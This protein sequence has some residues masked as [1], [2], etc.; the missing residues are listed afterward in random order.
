MKIAHV[1]N[2]FIC[3]ETNKSYLYYAQ[4]ITFKTMLNSK[5]EAQ[6]HNIDVKLYCAI[7]EE[8]E[9][10][11]PDHFIKLPYLNKSTMS[12]FPRHCKK[13]KL[14]FLQEIFDKML[15]IEADYFVFTNVDIALQKNFY[16]R[17]KYIIE[18]KSSSFAIN[19]R[20]NIP[21]FINNKRLTHN[22]LDILYQQNG[23]KHPGI[24]TFIIKREILE[25][26]NMGKL[27]T[28][29]PPWG[30]VLSFYLKKLDTSYKIFK[31]E[32]LTFHIGKDNDWWDKTDKLFYK[33]KKEGKKIKKYLKSL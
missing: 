9:K 4:P 27:F 13:K 33:N 14:P 7:F 21:K 32:Y 17:L 22:D 25:K 30:S 28:G 1:I 3:D 20:D 19:R 10:I 24:D 12:E 29:Y 11:V 18:N 15:K 2:P 23:E 26:I 5:L 8:D 6:K 31:N 16:I